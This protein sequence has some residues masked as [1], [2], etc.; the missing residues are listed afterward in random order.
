MLLLQNSKREDE[1]KKLLFGAL[2]LGMMLSSASAYDIEV[3]ELKDV[4]TC[5][6]PLVSF[7]I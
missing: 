2:A 5:V 3:R 4:H 6:R 7:Q 1:M